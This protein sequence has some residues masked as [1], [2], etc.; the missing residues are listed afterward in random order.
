[1]YQVKI[2]FFCLTTIVSS[3]QAQ[4]SQDF[5]KSILGTWNGEGSLFGQEASFKMKWKKDLNEQFIKLTFQNSF[6][7]QSGTQ[8]V[9]KATAYYNFEKRIGQWFDTRGVILPLTFDLDQNVMTVMWGDE[10]TEQGKTIYSLMNKGEMRVQ[11]FVLKD[12]LYKAFGEANYE[13]IE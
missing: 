13:R 1:M 10:K 3:V 9:L 7:D 6:K 5:S 4:T 11:D 12:D 2:I 8:R